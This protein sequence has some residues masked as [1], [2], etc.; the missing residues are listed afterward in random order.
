MIRWIFFFFFFNYLNLFSQ[1]QT[2]G[3][4]TNDAQSF[5][6]YTLFSPNSDTYLIDNCGKLIN[7]WNSNYNA[8]SSVYLLENGSLLRACRIQNPIFS[9]GGGGGR[10]EKTDWYGNLEWSYNF[11]DSLY[12]QH[13]DIAPLKNGNILI[14]C[15]E[16]KSLSE[17]IAAGRDPNSMIDNELWSTYILEVE[18]IGID[19]INI[20]WEWHLWD[21]L[22]QDFDSTKQNFGVVSQNP[23]LLD[24]NY[25]FGNGKNDWLHCNSIDYNEDLD[26]IVIG[27]RALSELYII[28]HS[29]TTIQASSNSGGNS[30]KGGDFLYRWG[31][32]QAYDAVSTDQKLFGQHDVH[33][34]DDSFL[35]G[36]K[37]LIF[38][39]GKQ[40]GYSSVDIVN[41]A[42]DSIGNY[43]IDS[44][45]M[46][47]PLNADWIYT[48]SPQQNFY[49]SYISGAQRLA[50]GN[51]LICDGA[52]GDFFEIDTLDNIVWRYVNPVLNTYILSQGDSIP[53]T[54]NGLGN[55]VFRCTKY[56]IDYSGFDNKDMT[57]SSPIELNPI[58]DSCVMITSILPEI[59]YGKEL[60]KIVD[61]MG[62]N[63]NQ[64]HN[65]VL[66][67]I[68]S[69]GT[70]EKI[71][72]IF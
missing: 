62:R 26:Q 8:G 56:P 71:F 51:T 7:S 64:E 37:L 19:S 48:S 4:F 13:H 12:H 6:G 3:L 29:T 14:L 40:R 61:L 21:H 18:P 54:Q 5:K 23:Q 39:N 68:Y 38:N 42:V 31:N 50:N 72:K 32:P 57:P 58:P 24:I 10:I 16:Y 69:D 47:Q 1:I 2:V 20:I 25:Y 44:L 33:W 34:I 55:S 46:F 30:N 53:V 60:I 15:W 9:A 28:D 43:I 70:V 11:S 59:S 52:H 35:D 63:T 36:G 41:P 27:S 49:S 17:S 65:S 22:V 67:Y 45:N 66:F